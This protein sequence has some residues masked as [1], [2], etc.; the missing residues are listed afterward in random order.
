[1]QLCSSTY[2]TSARCEQVVHA[3]SHE[4]NPLWGSIPK[5]GVSVSGSSFATL[6]EDGG[7]CEPGWNKYY[8]SNNMRRRWQG[9]ACFSEFQDLQPC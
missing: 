6:H 3:P 4:I 7:I 9:R 1:M 2:G 8:M 5:L